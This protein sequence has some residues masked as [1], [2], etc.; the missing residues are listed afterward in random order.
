MNQSKIKTI[1]SFQGMRFLVFLGI[2][3]THCGFS[4]LYR[5]AAYGVCFF[6]ML[7]GYLQGLKYYDT[8]KTIPVSSPRSCFNYAWHHLKKLYPLHVMTFLLAIPFTGL[9]YSFKTDGIRALPFWS[10]VS[11]LDLSLTKALVP[12]HYYSFNIVSWY[13]SAYFWLMIITLPL[14]RFIRKHKTLWFIPAAFGLLV[15]YSCFVIK[16]LPNYSEFLLYVFP[17]ARIPEYTIGLTLGLC[18]DTLYEKI[19][20]LITPLGYLS[21]LAILV[22]GIGSSL[23]LD[24]ERVLIWVIPNMFLLFFLHKSNSLFCKAISAPF[25]SKLGGMT[26]SMYLLHYIVYHY[27]LIS[28]IRYTGYVIPIITFLLTLLLAFLYQKFFYPKQQ[29]TGLIKEGRI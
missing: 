22:L 14:I 7:S 11:F 8:N 26:G 12:F 5:F 16:I 3:L 18:H 23:S 24:L 21:L 20:N 10:A 6:F 9:F 1:D 13:L 29:P 19:K 17:I 15:L 27:L 4:G 2:F 28:S 25:L